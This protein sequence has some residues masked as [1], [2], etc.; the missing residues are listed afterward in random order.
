MMSDEPKLDERSLRIVA[1]ARSGVG[2]EKENAR[3]ILRQI[4][5]KKHLD[6]DQVLA[7]TNDE[8][9]ERKLILGRLTKD[10]VRIIARV[11]M[12][13]GLSEDHKTLNV[14]YYGSKP[15]GFAFECNKA[16]F[17]ETEH[18]A[19]IYLLAFRK[20]RRQIMDSLSAAFVMKQHLYMPE[21]LREE[22]TSDDD[23]R[24]L[25]KKEREKLERD[26]TRAVMMAAGMD[27][28]QVHKAIEAN[29]R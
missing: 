25:T 16:T 27:G 29:G 3:R 9:T 24:E 5:E 28:V 1:L 4:C 8:I 12:N 2:G 21:F 10:E 20:E 11:I 18:A 23:D 19:N 6:F 7:G 22:M 13:F 17:I 14:L 15:A 26:H